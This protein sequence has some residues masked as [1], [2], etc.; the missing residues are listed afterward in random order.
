MHNDRHGPH[1]IPDPAVWEPEDDHT[2]HGA[3]AAALIGFACLLGSLVVIIVA[4][5]RRLW[6]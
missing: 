4:L 5:L 3:L 2:A 1:P 6:P